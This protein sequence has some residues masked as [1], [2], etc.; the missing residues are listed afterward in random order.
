MITVQEYAEKQGVSVRTVYRW[1]EQGKVKTDRVLDKLVIVS[2][3][4]DT[5]SDSR[6][7]TKDYTN[8]D[9]LLPPLDKRRVI[10][11]YE[12]QIE[13]LRNENEYLKNKLDKAQ[14]TINAQ[15][16]ER[17]RAQERSDTIILQLTRQFERQTLML[18]DM[19]NQSVWKR[20]KTAFGFGQRT[21]QQ[22]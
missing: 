7:K 8:N 14:E 17:E 5:N 16:V 1:V 9:E 2:D 20:I 19:Q 22:A 4:T 3:V 10:E 15:S 21:E 13:Q 11:S 18:E 6:I 12:A